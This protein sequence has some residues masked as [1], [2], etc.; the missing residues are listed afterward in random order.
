[1]KKFLLTFAAITLI[2]V[3]MNAQRIS[4]HAIGLRLGDSDGF[5]TEVNYQLGLG[6]NNRLEIGLGWRSSNDVTAIKAAALYQWVWVL[7]GNFNWYAGA[8]GGV[9]Q[10]NFDDDF[11]GDP[12]AE[13]FLFAA[14]DI[15]IEYNF[16][17]PLLLSLDFRPEFGFGDYRDDVDFDIALGIRYQF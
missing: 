8:G 5:G 2:S 6:E 16:D 17:I 1:M 10:V 9:G 7:D 11:P 14:G 4:K 12:D 13:T 3:S 15:G